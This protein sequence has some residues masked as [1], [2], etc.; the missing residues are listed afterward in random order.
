[1]VAYQS[2]EHLQNKLSSVINST[3]PSLIQSIC[4]NEFYK[5]TF[6]HSFNV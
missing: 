3:T 4:G 1:M 2:L 5:K 6:K